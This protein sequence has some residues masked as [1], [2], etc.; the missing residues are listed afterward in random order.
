MNRHAHDATS[1]VKRNSDVLPYRMMGH[2]LHQRVGF[3]WRYYTKVYR[4]MAQKSNCHH[5][6]CRVTAHK[7]MTAMSGVVRNI[8]TEQGVTYQPTSSDGCHAPRDCR[9]KDLGDIASGGA[10]RRWQLPPVGTAV[11]KTMPMSIQRDSD[12]NHEPHGECCDTVSICS[13]L[14][15]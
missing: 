6:K 11:H 4:K 12:T 7:M 8:A 5:P 14:R 2:V 1:I 15:L 10:S 13:A 3:P 9:V